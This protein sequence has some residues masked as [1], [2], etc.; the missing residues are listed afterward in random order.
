MHEMT[1]GDPE[2]IEATLRLRLG[3]TDVRY[4]TTLVAGATAMALFGDLETEIALRVYG[5]EGLCVAYHSVEFLA[6]LRTGDFVEG[7]AW[8]VGR[9]RTS[10][11]IRAEIHRVLSAG[12]DG[13]GEVS[14]PPV[15]AARAECTIVSGRRGSHD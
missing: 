15:L 4:G 1:P 3:P 14:D 2:P 7:R 10:R 9:G 11:R 6:P 5:D 12:P 13:V 8:I